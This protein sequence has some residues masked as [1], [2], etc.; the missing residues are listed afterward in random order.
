MKEKRIAYRTW[1]FFLCAYLCAITT[2]EAQKLDKKEVERYFKAEKYQE[3]FDLLKDAR[4]LKDEKL[5][6]MRGVSAYH[7]RNLNQ[8]IKDLSLL[9]QYE[10]V[11]KDDVLLYLGH[12]LLSSG[13][14][15]E[16]AVWYK[17]YLG[18]VEDASQE[19]R[20]EVIHLIQVCNI[21]L[22]APFQ[23]SN[24]FVENMGRSVNSR[25]DEIYPTQSPN[26]P[27][28]YY[29]SSNREGAT[30][31]MRDKERLKDEK[32]GEFYF[33][34]YSVELEKGN[35]SEVEPID[36]LINTSA[37]E[38]L[39]DFNED[40]RVLYYMKSGDQHTGQVLTDTFD[41]RLDAHQLS[42]V[43]YSPINGKIG[44]KYLHF[45]NPETLIFASNRKGG[46]GG[47]DLYYSLWKDGIWTPAIN[48][49][50]EVN[51]AFDE[52]SPYFAHS[53]RTL[54]YSSNREGSIGGYDVFQ[55]AFSFERN[56]WQAA[57]NMNMPINS[58]DDDLYFSLGTDGNTGVLSSN[59]P[60]GQG[61]FDLYLVYL[62]EVI[63]NKS[64]LDIDFGQLFETTL[65][66]ERNG[67][68][69]NPI[70]LNSN[71]VIQ[72]KEVVLSPLY[73]GEDDLL[74][75][76]DNLEVLAI[77]VDILKVYPKT[78]V[79]LT[80]NS[81]DG[82]RAAFQLFFSVKRAEQVARYLI[83]KGIDQERIQVHGL[84]NKF[85]VAF[86]PPD[87]KSSKVVKAANNRIDI[88]LN[89]ADLNYLS[90]N[91]QEPV[92]AD[93]LRNKAYTKYKEVLRKPYFK[94]KMAETSQ[95]FRD[96]I[97]E[98]D[99]FSIAKDGKSGM[100]TYYV[101]L[102]NSFEEIK[103][104]R[105]MLIERKYPTPIIQLFINDQLVPDSDLDPLAK[106]YPEIATFKAEK[107]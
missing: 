46:F 60:G 91:Y 4:Y 80:G 65:N 11:F 70:D 7:I 38:F 76:E 49:G 54:F 67:E 40:G 106:A 12:V 8:A 59:R 42:N 1:V 105:S 32:Y 33:D 47:Y 77:L 62:K 96:P 21:G 2:L 74:L 51:S 25:K 81:D 64:N 66:T 72:T 17:L 30:G 68:L 82:N 102:S 9:A 56:E 19:E 20:A 10:D 57:Q 53:G 97:L 34:M 71:R 14:Y 52:L 90:V 104:L 63:D 6:Y 99:G 94:I 61:G 37:S 43:F 73:Y 84:G 29:F 95:M 98:M 69:Q 41:S 93:Y 89:N 16:A 35:W 23:E 18:E 13:A 78:S 83:D 5:L 48:M 31:G 88:Q 103:Q 27:N 100:Y 26:H 39:L 101:G 58:P 79:S 50:P 55:Q 85:P 28:K 3:S 22:K 44:D 107:K 36:P 92:I 15:E 87:G 86:D 24:G 45:L 75:T